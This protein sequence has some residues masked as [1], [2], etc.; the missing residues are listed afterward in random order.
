MERNGTKFLGKILDQFLIRISEI[1]EYKEGV[2]FKGG[3]FFL[4]HKINW[5]HIKTK[6]ASSC[7]DALGGTSEIRTSDTWIFSPLLYQLSYGTSVV[8]RCKDTTFFN[9]SNKKIYFF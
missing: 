4:L 7:E 2:T 6:K 3:V 9:T 1:Q 8:L 5:N